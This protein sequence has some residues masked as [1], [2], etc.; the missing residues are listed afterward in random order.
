M[1]DS[2]CVSPEDG[3]RKIINLEIERKGKFSIK[4]NYVK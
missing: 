1:A 4:I 3:E 2:T